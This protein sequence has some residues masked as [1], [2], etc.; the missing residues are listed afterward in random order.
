MEDK[1]KKIFGNIQ[2][3]EYSIFPSLANS[4]KEEFEKGGFIVEIEQSINNE[5]SKVEVFHDSEPILDSSI[6]ILDSKYYLSNYEDS[7]FHIT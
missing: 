6:F 4:I 5:P 7:F 1:I 2:K 3:N